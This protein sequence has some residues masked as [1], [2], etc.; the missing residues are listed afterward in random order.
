[1]II[2]AYRQRHRGASLQITGQADFWHPAAK[3]L[4]KI[5]R[6]I[7][8]KSDVPASASATRANCTAGEWPF[9]EESSEQ[10][11]RPWPRSGVSEH[12]LRGESP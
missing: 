8:Q 2:M 5:T 10:N 4:T 9:G 12:P 7:M 6:I 1:M 11:R 3:I